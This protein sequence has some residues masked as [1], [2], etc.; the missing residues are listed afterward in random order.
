MVHIHYNVAGLVRSTTRPIPKPRLTGEHGYN[1]RIWAR[2]LTKS[3][4]LLILCI[5]T[6][7]ND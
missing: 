1:A 5:P 6:A 7:P 3:I 2:L 4:I